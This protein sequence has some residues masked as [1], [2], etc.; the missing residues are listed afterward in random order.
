[1]ADSHGEQEKD[2]QLVK[3]AAAGD[4][5][6]FGILFD[7][8][9]LNIYRFLRSQVYDPFEAENLTSEVFLRAWRSL[10][11]YRDLGH[12]FSTYLFRIAR[13]AVIDQ[14]R[15][16]RVQVQP[17]NTITLPGDD[18]DRPG[19]ALARN[20]E[21]KLLY[22]GLLGLKEVHRSV[23]VLRFLIGL[24]N[25]EVAQIMDRSEGAVRV[26][27]HRALKKLRQI[28]VSMVSKDK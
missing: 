7:R 19:E 26:L 13:N 11:S 5:Q 8:Y 16:N 27:Q 12:P 25:G 3:E 15:K 23:L 9:S 24:S 21:L 6:A 10:P 20:Q 17:L 4:H 1:M 28:M 14:R 22:E 2:A 18:M